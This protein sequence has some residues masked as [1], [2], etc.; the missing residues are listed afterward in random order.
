MAEYRLQRLSARVR[1]A[2]RPAVRVRSCL[3]A[4]L[5][6][7]SLTGARIEHLDILRPG[8]HCTV[9][10]P[11][12]IGA[13]VLSSQIAWSNVV[14][15]E[16]GPAGERLLLYESGLAFLGVSSRQQTSLATALESL[17]ARAR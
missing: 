4:R 5:V 2:S 9:E 6:D 16:R 7:M 13:L 15:T 12:A 1:I 14:G 3:S 10:L 17:M 8:F 11:K